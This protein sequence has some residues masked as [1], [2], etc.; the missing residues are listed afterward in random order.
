MC[1]LLLRHGANANAEDSRDP[2]ALDWVIDRGHDTTVGQL[3]REREVVMNG[4]RSSRKG[5]CL[6]V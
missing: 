3:A 5:S 6:P 1:S 2:T 4:A